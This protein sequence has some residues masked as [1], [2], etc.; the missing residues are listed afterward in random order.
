MNNPAY[1][2][3]IERFVNHL[4]SSGLKKRLNLNDEDIADTF[5]LALQMG[6]EKSQIVEKPDQD[7]LK[8][9]INDNNFG[10]NQTS[11]TVPPP[12]NLYTPPPDPQ[13]K[14]PVT[15]E[16]LPFQTPAAPALQNK[17]QI[18]RALR[19]F[20]RKFPSPTRRILDVE[21]TVNRIV[22]GLIVEQEIWLPVTQPEP[23]RWLNLELVIE[24]NRSSFIWQETIN[25]LQDILENYG[26]FRNLSSDNQNNLQLVSRKKGKQKNQ[27]QY[28]YRELYHSNGRGLILI[29]T[30]CV[31]AIW[32]QETIYNWL[33]KWSNQSPTA[34][35]QLLP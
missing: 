8:E 19:P 17:S 24:E 22:D 21:A 10:E 5:W 2:D 18:N 28:S 4:E 9:L 6:V 32:Q 7:F 34:I 27:C 11:E 31:S 1:Y 16:G 13:P 25:E 26:I 3:A 23:E 20:M 35:M 12:I 29:V 30:D 14:K 33:E 15:R